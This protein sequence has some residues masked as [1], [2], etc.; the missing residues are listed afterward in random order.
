MRA[1]NRIL[2]FADLRRGA[3]ILHFPIQALTLW[4]FHC[5]F[6]LERWRRAAGP[7]VHDW[8]TA[9]GEIDALA[10]LAAIRRDNPEWCVSA[11]HIRRV[12]RAA[13]LGHPLLPAERRVAND[14]TLGPPGTV[15][16]ITGS[17]MSGKSTLLRAIGVNAVLAEAGAPVCASALQMP[18]CDI[19]TSI[20]IQ[21]SLEQGV[22]YFM[23][24]LARLK[25][26][27]DA[28]ERDRDQGEGGACSST[29]STRSSRGP[30]A[31]SVASR[32]RPSPG[33]CSTPAR[34]AR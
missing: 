4:D 32:F 8:F 30:T 12:Y 14:V 29:C 9:A 28:A 18:P 34:S 5:L 7:R 27:I 26:V 19:Q 2:G 16:L 15:L 24:A 22:S 23:A 20:R 11:A 33:T 1:L 10:C 3:A 13:A 6:A 17:N 21:D 25:G 31:P